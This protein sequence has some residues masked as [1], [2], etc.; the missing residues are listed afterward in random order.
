[1]PDLSTNDIAAPGDKFWDMHTDP[2]TCFDGAATTLLTIQLNLVAG[3]LASY[4]RPDLTPLIDAIVCF[5][6][7]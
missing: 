7:M 6:T 2:I 4:G 3:T 1:M 5:K